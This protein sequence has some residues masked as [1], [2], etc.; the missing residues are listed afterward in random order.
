METSCHE[1]SSF[2]TTF[3]APVLSLVA[4]SLAGFRALIEC[5]EDFAVG[6]T[7]GDLRQCWCL[8]AI[9]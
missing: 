9:R 4:F 6:V 7:W 5:V 3:I 2:L 1:R 8:G